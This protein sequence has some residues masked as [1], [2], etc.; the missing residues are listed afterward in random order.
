M[1]HT[2]KQAAPVS[3]QGLRAFIADI[4]ENRFTL[5]SEKL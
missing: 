1:A 2:C 5:N 4:G 3:A